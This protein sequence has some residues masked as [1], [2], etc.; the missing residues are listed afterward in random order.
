MTRYVPQVFVAP[1]P[2]SEA[3]G[4]PMLAFLELAHQV[5]LLPILNKHGLGRIE[6]DQWYSMQSALDIF[7]AFYE[8][9]SGL[10]YG[11]VSIGMKAMKTFQFPQEVNSVETALKTIDHIAKMF[12]RNVPEDFGFPVQFQGEGH[13][14]IINNTPIPD[15][16]VYG[17]IWNIVNNYK[18]VEETFLVRL[19]NTGTD[20][21]TVLEVK[22]G[23]SEDGLAD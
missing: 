17:F 11:L 18:A 21:P 19:L 6:A 2:D 3:L 13:A 1:Y 22:W 23:Y 15:S 8:T 9:S 7:R 5:P 20:V 16:G 12:A 10:N 4:Q 14:L